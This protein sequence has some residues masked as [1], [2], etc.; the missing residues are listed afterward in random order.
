MASGQE[1]ALRRRIRGIESTKKLTRAMEL[2]S[3]SQIVRA[4]QRI[5]QARP[6]V[7]GLNEALRIAADDATEPTRFLGEPEDPRRVLVVATV[8]DRGLCGAYNIN[9]LR[10]TERR[11]RQGESAGR[12]YTLVT[13]GR[14]A[15]S[16]FRFRSRA[17][18][19]SFDKMTERPTFEDARRVAAAITE[20]F[21]SGGVDLVEVVSTRFRSAGVQTVE[22]R[23]LLPLI[24]RDAPASRDDA[25]GVPAGGFYDFEPRSDDL[26]ELLAPAVVEAELF[27]A[28]L[29]ASASEHT[30]RQRA[31]SAATENANE[32]GKTLRREMNRVRQEAITTEI[33]E[34]VGGAEALRNAASMSSR[35]DLM[36]F[37][38]NEER[39]E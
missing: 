35:P 5:S 32:L 21:V 31:M 12:E 28:L 9:V 20:P 10:A 1:R 7:D 33:M 30:A 37:N 16:F 8:S 23:Q 22:I 2:I 34:I 29:E 36:V 38:D 25:E 6:Y 24:P 15:Q 14:K 4:Q 19:K 26:I 27:G 39:N 18:D 3:A 17:I 11:V 13:V